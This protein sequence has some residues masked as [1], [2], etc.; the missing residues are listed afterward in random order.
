MELRQ[1]PLKF[2]LDAAMKEL[3]RRLDPGKRYTDEEF[4]I[5]LE[6]SVLHC[7]KDGGKDG[8]KDGGKDGG[9]DGYFS[10]EQK[11]QVILRIF[12]ARRRLDLLQPLI[13]HPDVDEIMVNGI[14]GIFTER[15]GMLHKEELYIDDEAQLL[16]LIQ[17][18]V[19]KVNR[20]I[21]E[22]SPVVD[23]RLEDGSRIHAVV[24]PVALDGPVLTIRKFKPQ[25]FTMKEL[26]DMEFISCE[27]ADFLGEL[28]RA[29][30]NLFISGGAGTGKTTFLNVLAGCIPPGE[31]V[32]TIEDSAELNIRNVDNLVRLEARPPNPGGAD[33]VTVRDLLKAALRMRPDRIIVGEIRS[34]EALDMLQ[35]MN[36]GHDGS[37][38]TGHANSTTDMLTR[39]ET[40]AMFT[41]ILP[42]EAIRRQI[43]SAVE[44]LV[45]L[46]R[47]PDARRKV[48]EISEVDAYNGQMPGLRSL[49]RLDNGILKSTGLSLQKTEKLERYRRK[50]P[51]PKK[52]GKHIESLENEIQRPA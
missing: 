52:G 37:L 10:L 42:L 25:T 33:G 24:P 43:A 23:A 40:M 46:I 29:R 49:Y 34:G 2:L 9:K 14:T 47:M 11:R 6:E 13:D 17:R 44:I 32:I 35:A 22:A 20:N 28:V 19:S 8:A 45:H 26:E 39:M 21:N 36:T 48:A 51:D 38:S 4:L 41:G 3:D 27:A 50:T 30:Y 18:I 5:L 16:D 31:R 12:N 7:G 15:R 1:D